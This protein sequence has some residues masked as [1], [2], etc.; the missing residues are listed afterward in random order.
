MA[1]QTQ[2]ANQTSFFGGKES[3]P[4]T[5]GSSTIN[6]EMGKDKPQKRKQETIQRFD[7]QG[8]AQKKEE[9]GL[10]LKPSEASHDIYT[11]LGDSKT[12]GVKSPKGSQ[13]GRF[14]KKEF[15]DHRNEVVRQHED[16]LRKA[17]TIER[18][19][20]KEALPA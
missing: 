7:T 12:K 2:N 8:T 5:I 6:L 19:V 15:I 17:Q 13:K 1:S 3:K 20:G 14:K 9:A 4:R 16:N 18:M 11:Q 10:A